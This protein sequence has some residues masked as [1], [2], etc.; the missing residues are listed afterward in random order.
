LSLRQAVAEV[1]QAVAVVRVALSI[2]PGK[3]LLHQTPIRILLVV[4]G[5]ERHT[6]VVLLIVE[7]TPLLIRLPPLEAAAALVTGLMALMEVLE[8]VETLDTTATEAL[9][10]RAIPAEELDTATMEGLELVE[11]IGA[12]EAEVQMPPVLPVKLYLILLVQAVT[13][14]I[15]QTLIC[16]ARTQV[17]QNQHQT[18]LDQVKVILVAADQEVEEQLHL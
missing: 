18:A 16:T 5:Q 9:E 8:G 11:V 3:V 14:S 10:L 12:V 4:A 1:A 2:T 15:L 6:M 13:V 7:A 17:M